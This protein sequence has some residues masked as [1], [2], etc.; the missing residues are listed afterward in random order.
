MGI[1]TMETTKRAA[2]NWFPPRRKEKRR[3]RGFVLLLYEVGRRPGVPANVANAHA[4]FE[5]EAR[6]ALRD[7]LM[8]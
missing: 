2:W 6:T 7:W 3:H 4:R 8:L 1:A 5:H